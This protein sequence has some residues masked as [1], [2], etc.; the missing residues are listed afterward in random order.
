MQ[1]TTGSKEKDNKAES[2]TKKMSTDDLLEMIDYIAKS[3]RVDTHIYDYVSEIIS[4]TRK[5]AKSWETNSVLSYGASTRAGLALIRAGRVRAIMDGRD[6]MLP[7]DIKHLAH[8]VLDHRIGLSYESMSDGVTTY[9]V[10]EKILD[11]VRIP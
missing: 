2:L 4:A 7:E 5:L 11:S 1:E 10:T 9:S 8:D 6:Y 3:V